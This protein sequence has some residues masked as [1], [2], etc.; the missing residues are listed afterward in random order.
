[1]SLNSVIV[2]GLTTLF[3]LAIGALAAFS[4]SRLRIRP[5]GSACSS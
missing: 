1:M 4:L 2:A 5:A 3:C